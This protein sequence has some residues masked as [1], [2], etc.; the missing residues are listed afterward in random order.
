MKSILKALYTGDLNITDPVFPDDDNYRNMSRN[1]DDIKISLRDKLP[2][3]NADMLEKL[4]TL[5]YEI[6]G[7]DTFEGFKSGF[8]IGALIM[9]EVMTSKEAN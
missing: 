6:A 9:L 2:A 8:C 5:Q 4:C 7:F 3:D 1:I